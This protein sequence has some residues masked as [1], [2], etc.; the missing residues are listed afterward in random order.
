[1]EQFLLL[2]VHL[3]SYEYLTSFL[4]CCYIAFSSLGFVLQTLNVMAHELLC[5]LSP[6]FICVA[7]SGCVICYM[8]LKSWFK[9]G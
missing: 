6:A 9:S 1:M 3:T 5:P 7:L 4:L 2:Q 8:F